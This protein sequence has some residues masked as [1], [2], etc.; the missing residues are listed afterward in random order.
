M[1][2]FDSHIHIG[3]KGSAEHRAMLL[4]AVLDSRIHGWA[5]FAKPSLHQRAVLH[6][7]SVHSTAPYVVHS[8]MGCI[9][10]DGH[11][12]A[13]PQQGNMWRMLMCSRP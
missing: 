4:R 12:K 9:G 6:S 3:R 10:T 8:R 7:V 11:E 13:I 5:S 2:V 1:K